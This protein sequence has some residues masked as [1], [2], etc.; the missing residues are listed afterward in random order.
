MK[1]TD[2][3]QGQRLAHLR[4]LSQGHLSS[5]F[6]CLPLASLKLGNKWSLSSYLRRPFP[7]FKI[8]G[9]SLCGDWTTGNKRLSSNSGLSQETG[10]QAE[11]VHVLGT[12]QA[13]RPG[14]PCNRAYMMPSTGDPLRP[15]GRTLQIWERNP[16]QSRRWCQN[17]PNASKMSQRKS[18]MKRGLDSGHN[19]WEPSP[20]AL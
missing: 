7:T 20:D 17:S 4:L 16:G 14:P 5:D 18:F 3:L 2:S 15:Q 19:G 6:L 13:F 1:A 9:T 12:S 10:L 11:T 8:S